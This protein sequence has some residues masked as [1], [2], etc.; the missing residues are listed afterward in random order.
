LSL[1]WSA[2]LEH[3]RGTLLEHAPEHILPFHGIMQAHLLDSITK[4]KFRDEKTTVLS[5]GVRA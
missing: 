2:D 1:F 3:F 4:W 5:K